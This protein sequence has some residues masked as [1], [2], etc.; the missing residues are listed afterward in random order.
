VDLTPD[1]LAAWE[2]TGEFPA[3]VE[4]RFA[5]LECSESRD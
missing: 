2:A 4:A 1:E 3:S 5:A